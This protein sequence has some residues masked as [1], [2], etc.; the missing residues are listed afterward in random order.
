MRK[1]I[2]M[3]CLMAAA[4]VLSSCGN[5]DPE[6]ESIFVNQE[7]ANQN[8]FDKWIYRNYTLPYNMKVIYKMQDIESDYNYTLAPADYVKSVELAHIV[9]YAWLDAYD[10]VAGTDFTRAYVPKILHLI[11]SA[12]YQDNGTMVLGTAEG[13]L[14][15]TL[16]LVN[17]LQIN[18]DLLNEYY[19]KTMHHEFSH[20]LHQTKSYDPS[21]DLISEGH[22]VNGDWYLTSD[23]EARKQGFVSAY[24]SSEA[25]EDIAE[26]TSIYITYT[27]QEWAAVLADAGETG[28]PIIEQ[29]LDI[30]KKYMQNS[31]GIDLDKLR[32]VVQRRMNDIVKGSVD[33]YNLK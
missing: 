18:R 8:D 31:W 11:G 20:I 15:V 17:S 6:G 23:E 27:P 28:A 19:F 25:R 30:V 5:D 24:A 9:K 1:Y 16:Y 21:Y 22:Y 13:G 2:Y 26:V 10:E 29:K 32:S 14:K 33:L 12:A 7:A 4:L 3:A